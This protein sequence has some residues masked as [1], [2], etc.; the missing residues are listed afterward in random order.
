MTI[1][2]RPLRVVLIAL[3]AVLAAPAQSENLLEIYR[4]AQ[5]SDPALAA[6]R[7]NWSATQEKLPEARAALLPSA[8]LTGSANANTYDQNI[9][10]DPRVDISR[11]YNA[12]TLTISAAQPLYRRQNRIA[13]DQAEVQV[14][15]ADHAL[16]AAKQDLIVRVA[17]A[18]FD[19]L[20]AQFSV[21]T[22][23]S[24]KAAVSEQLAQ[25]R[26]N[27]EVGVAT[28][29][30]TNE[31]QAQ[32]D[33][34]VAQEISTRNHVDNK[35]TALRAIIGRQPRELARLAAAYDPK[36]PEPNSAEWWVSKAL[37]DNL[38]V[39]I[40]QANFDIA[41][42]EVDR[43]RAG[44]YPTVDLV[45][46]Y[47]GTTGTGSASLGFG[48]SFTQGQIGVQVAVPIYQGGGIEARVREAVAL[49]ERTRQDLEAARRAA[50][51]NAQTGFAG[52]NSAVASVK[53]FEQA[54]VSAQTAYDS[55]RV[56]QEVG[57]RTN[58]DVLNVQQNVFQRRRDLAQAYFAHIT[59]VLKLKAAVGTLSEQD[60]EEVNRRL[61][62]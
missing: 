58:L 3:S 55:N 49:R 10:S 13:V 15:Q 8:T 21:E 17:T 25:A 7:A 9:R 39:R 52:V 24:Q 60:L 27:F 12:G 50:L 44:H 26:R 22:V 14:A 54:L 6:A 33:S 57:V 42:L 43:A 28:I 41:T 32:Y 62:S 35:I 53:A 18:Y 51:F 16:E 29:T 20:L 11:T 4:T 47:T 36:P 56:G 2:L 48:N 34:I 31:A 59:G 19:V 1:K 40:A 38:P 37:A 5:E 30:D 61:K 23:V 46:F 45:G